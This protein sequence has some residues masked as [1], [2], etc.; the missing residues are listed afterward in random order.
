MEEQ[1]VLAVKNTL[2]LFGLVGASESF[3]RWFR[4]FTPAGQRAN[5]HRQA[6][7]RFYSQFIRQGD[8]CYDVGANLGSRVGIFLKLGARVVAVEPQERCMRYL[9]QRFQDRQRVILIPKGLDEKPGE[10]DLLMANESAV[11]SM[12][13]EWVHQNEP[14]GLYRWDKKAA[15][16]VTTLDNLIQQYG[17]P[18]FCKIDVE[19]FEYHVLKGLS[20][21]LPALSLEYHS[22]FLDAVRSSMSHLQTLGR[23]EFNFSVAETMVLAL[24]EWLTPDEICP[25]LENLPPESRAG[26]IYARLKKER[27]FPAS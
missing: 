23:Y 14:L 10:R 27:P 21:P 20:Q 7:L 26:D 4:G 12:S 15:V 5:E 8:L 6:M 22:D 19:G 9:R 25:L 1:I 3:V 2:G 16:P 17:L 24:A 18:T 11:S 13:Q